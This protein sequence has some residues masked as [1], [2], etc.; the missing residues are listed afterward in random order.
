MSNAEKPSALLVDDNEATCTLITAL[1]HREFRVE[2]ASDGLEAVEKLR[3]N[4]YAVVLLDLRM[5]QHDG[6]SV[7]DFLKANNPEILK[8]VLVVTAMLNRREIDHANS[9]GICGIVTKPF[10][11]DMLLAEVRKCVGDMDRGTLGNVFCSSTPMILL[12]A[13]LLRQRLG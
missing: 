4:Q 11:V 6:F 10:D 9:Y 1:L 3:I 2:T 8:S 12:I 5:P 7:L 13:D